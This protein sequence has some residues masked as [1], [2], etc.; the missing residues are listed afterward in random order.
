MGVVINE[1]L[2]FVYSHFGSV[3]QDSIL[4]VLSSFFTE[5]ELVKAKNVIY[6]VL[7]E[8]LCWNSTS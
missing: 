4:A 1:L 3:P 8:K 7:R 2:C 5:E 6:E